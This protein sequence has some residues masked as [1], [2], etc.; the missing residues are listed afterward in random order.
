MDL[1]AAHPNL[2]VANT[3]HHLTRLRAAGIVSSRKHGTHVANA[4]AA[5]ENPERLHGEAA[6]AALCGA[7]QFLATVTPCSLEIRGASN[8]D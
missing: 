8:M 5:S 3:S 1:I 2:S 4:L 6:F 7:I